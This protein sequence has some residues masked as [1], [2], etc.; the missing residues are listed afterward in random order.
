MK[1]IIQKTTLIQSRTFQ[2]IQP[3]GVGLATR[4]ATSKVVA[5][6]ITIMCKPDSGAHLAARNVS[7]THS[8]REKSAP[9][10]HPNPLIFGP[11][12]NALKASVF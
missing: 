12:F 6:C 10:H 4:F 5:Q 11:K 3:K 7:F 8:C 1:V 2:S 9:S